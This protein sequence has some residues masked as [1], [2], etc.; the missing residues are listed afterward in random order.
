MVDTWGQTA[1][2][3]SGNEAD[4]YNNN[5]LRPSNWTAAEYVAEYV[6]RH[7]VEPID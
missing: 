3:L 5:G 2:L 6:A 7:R 1:I 4:L